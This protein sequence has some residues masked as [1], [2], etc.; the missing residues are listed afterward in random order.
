MIFETRGGA[1]SYG[2]DG[3]ILRGVNFRVESGETLSILGANGAGKTTIVK[4]AAGLR[5]WREGATYLDGADIRRLPPKIFRRRVG[6]VPQA[7]PSAFAYTVTEMVMLGRL[8]LMGIFAQPGA[9]DVRKAREALELAGAAHLK[10]RLCS[11]IS[12]GEY[13]LAVLAR[14]LASEPSL[15]ILDEPESNLDFKN[16][17][18]ILSIVSS[19][20]R[21][22][23]MSAVFSTHY[24][25]HALELSQKSLLVMPG[26]TTLF[27]ASGEITTEENLKTAF[28]I[29][30]A[31]HRFK[32]FARERVCAAAEYTIE[33]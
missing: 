16:Q 10:D 4:C 2:A 5:A 24:P 26:G 9:C 33:K 14:A 28:G 19:L 20:C 7:R 13:Q 27:G 8:P 18:R 31:L 15:L 22:R 1:F 11:R 23:K 6:Y 17:A 12:G 30:V 25:E 32:A 29:P 21:E 3:Y